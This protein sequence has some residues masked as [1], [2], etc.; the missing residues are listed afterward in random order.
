MPN[1]TAAHPNTEHA[2]IERA[3]LNHETAE[4][5]WRDLQKLFA[6][7]AVYAVAAEADLIEVALQISL[8]N[9][10]AV[11]AWLD[12]G[13]FAAVSDELALKWFEA[14]AVLWS[15]VVKPWVLVQDN[16]RAVSL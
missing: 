16:P 8:D 10:A 12:D 2:A 3:K 1:E 7:G 15:V 13:T 11:K 9:A 5:N 14:D 6:Q 4:I